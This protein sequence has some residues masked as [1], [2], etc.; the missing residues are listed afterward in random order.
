MKVIVKKKIERHGEGRY[1]TPRSTRFLA[2]D[3]FEK[4]SFGVN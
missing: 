4:D 3:F 1:N 2:A